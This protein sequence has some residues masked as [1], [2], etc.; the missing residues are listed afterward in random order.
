[1]RTAAVVNLAVVAGAID[2]DT[3]SIAIFDIGDVIVLYVIPGDQVMPNGFRAQQLRA[4]LW[5]IHVQQNIDCPNGLGQAQR[6]KC[7]KNRIEYLIG[8]RAIAQ[9]T[10]QVLP[11]ATFCLAVYLGDNGY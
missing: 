2:K 9:G 5:N 7:R 4:E 6:R 11:K 8:R 10:R 3:S 1:M